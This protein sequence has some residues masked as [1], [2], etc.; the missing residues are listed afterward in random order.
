MVNYVNGLEILCSI[1]LMLVIN[2]E[3][4]MEP[5]LTTTSKEQPPAIKRPRTRVRIETTMEPPLTTTSKEQPHAVTAKNSGPDW[6]YNDFNVKQP[7]RNGHLSTP[8]NE[9]LSTPQSALAI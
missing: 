2:I 4:T 6:N 7:L 5:P 1:M 8:Y 9:Q 3:T